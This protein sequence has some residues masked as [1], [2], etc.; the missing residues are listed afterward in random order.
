MTEQE[1]QNL[2]EGETVIA[3]GEQAEIKYF[4]EQ[5]AGVEFDDGTVLNFEY[6]KLSLA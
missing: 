5:G 1:F 4:T 3:N 6:P 2:T